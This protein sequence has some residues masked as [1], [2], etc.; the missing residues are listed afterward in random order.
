MLAAFIGPLAFRTVSVEAELVD[1]VSKLYIST[2][3]LIR[4]SDFLL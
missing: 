2:F 4:S 1:G 3:C